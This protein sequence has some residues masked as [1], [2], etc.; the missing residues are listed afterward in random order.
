MVGIN[1]FAAETDE[2]AIR[3]ATSHLQAHLSLA[4]GAPIELPL[5]LAASRKCSREDLKF[6]VFARLN[7]RKPGHGA[8]RLALASRAYARRRAD[9]PLDDL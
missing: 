8:E 7:Y 4:R 3:L 5:R 6:I 1:V 2:E 9:D